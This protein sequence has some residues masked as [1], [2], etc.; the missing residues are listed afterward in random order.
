[1]SEFISR[2]E[3]YDKISDLEADVKKKLLSTPRDSEAYIRYVERLNERSVFK[4]E[5]L[6]ATGFYVRPVIYGDWESDSGLIFPI[7]SCSVCNY[8]TPLGQT[9]FCPNCGADMRKKV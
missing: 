8:P 2:K 9:N 4:K 6:N 1:M 7:Y 5:I 3:L